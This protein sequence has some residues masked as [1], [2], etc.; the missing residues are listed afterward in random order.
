MKE[1][2]ELVELVFETMKEMLGRGENVRISGFG[3]FVLR[4]KRERPGR[5]PQ[6][7]EPLVL[8]ARR[9]LTFKGCQVL[10]LA[11]NPREDSRATA[12]EE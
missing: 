8:A 5:N 10:K 3:N 4:N 1:A 11:L 9:V 6:T 7:G 2:D 12:V